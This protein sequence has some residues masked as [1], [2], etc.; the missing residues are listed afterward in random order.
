MI[1]I[2]DIEKK[3]YNKITKTNWE[4]VLDPWFNTRE[5]HNILSY[6]YDEY[7][8][9]IMFEPF[10]NDIFKSFEQCNYNDLKCILILDDINISSITNLDKG[11]LIISPELTRIINTPGSHMKGWSNFIKSLLRQLDN[12]PGLFYVFQG[13]RSARYFNLVEHDFNHV[14]KVNNVNQE[15]IDKINNIIIYK[16]DKIR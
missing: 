1:D 16:N 5:L 12:T 15:L 14:Y 4:I 3:L 6:L 10:V 11:T 9:G 2:D 7:K 8:K 13:E